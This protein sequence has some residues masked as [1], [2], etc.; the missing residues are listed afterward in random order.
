[1]TSDKD[2]LMA[3]VLE[4]G[5]SDRDLARVIGKQMLDPEIEAVL[6]GMASRG[7]IVASRATVGHRYGMVP[8]KGTRYFPT[9]D[10]TARA[11]MDY[12]TA[13]PGCTDDEVNVAFSPEGGV[14]N[15]METDIGRLERE[16]RI[17]IEFKGFPGDT[18][19][20]LSIK[21]TFVPVEGV[22]G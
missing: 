18:P 22:E 1:M 14:P 20:S 4:P 21:R 8:V 19:N 3:I 10:G 15:W 12:V 11:L 6:F 13:H 5:V 7:E 9:A 2:I 16:G 17:R